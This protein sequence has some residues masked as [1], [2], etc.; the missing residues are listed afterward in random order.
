MTPRLQTASTPPQSQHAKKKARAHAKSQRLRD[1][2]QQRLQAMP[3]TRQHAA[4]IDI[5]GRSHWVCV[6]FTTD[7]T[8]SPLVREFPSHTDGLMDIVAYLREH[9]VTDVALEATGVYW[10]A[11]LEILQQEKFTVILVDPSYTKQLRGR[12]KTD[13]K[14]AQ[15][16][17]RLHSVGLLPAAF[18]PD[19]TIAVLRSYVRHRSMTVRQAGQCV[20]RM[21]KALEQMNLKVTT[22]LDDIT[23]K[24][25]LAIIRSILCGTR[26]PRKLAQHRHR[27]CRHSEEE[28]AQALRG[29]YRD[30]HVFTLRSA[31]E[32]WRFFQEQLDKVDVA[33]AAQLKKMAGQKDLPP[34]SAKKCS[35][36]RK[37]N[38]PRFDARAALYAAVGM[39][40][41]E[42]EGL[43]EAT[44][45]TL[46]S[47][48][49][50]DMSRFPTVK[51]F[52]SWLGLC[53]HWR[54]TGGKVKS[55][56]TRSGA[57]R[58]ATALCLAAGSLHRSRSAL[59]AY[60]RRMKSRLGKAAGITATAHKL[61]RLLYW[62]LS[63]GMA[64]VKKT[65]DNYEEDQ[66]NRARKHLEKQ[67]RRL[68]L[69]VIER[70]AAAATATAQ[71]VGEAVG[72]TN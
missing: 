11:L 25:G 69:E 42:L 67:A 55:S 1:E 14:D 33:I 51:H 30:E 64:Y 28:I 68:G 61:A 13:R 46:I 26:D 10:I 19:E 65:Q 52:C 66:R 49:G 20:Q 40:L 45:L 50:L 70:P 15:W 8:R 16:I 7:A 6:G 37:A 2:D 5:G 71:L 31:Y 41:T 9:Q 23:G 43:S 17:H 54:K 38:D 4:G 32:T 27:Q 29:N 39:D 48:I 24:T 3:I 63:K 22:V 21:Q 47:E 36:G 62:S 53:P 60:L 57:N 34:L 59:G 12:P 58:A 72:A 56:R 44:V 35:S 18:R